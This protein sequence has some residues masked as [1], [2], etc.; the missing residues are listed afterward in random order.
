[1]LYKA[2]P[3]LDKKSL[4]ALYFSFINSYVNYANI[5]WGSTYRTSLKKINSLV[6]QA[7]RIL[8]NKDKYAHSRPLLRSINALDVYQLNVYQ[9]INLMYQVK[10]KNIPLTL[11]QKFKCISHN[12]PTNYSEN[13]YEIPKIKNNFAKFSISYRGP[14]PW[15]NFLSNASKEEESKT[16]FQKSLKIKLFDEENIIRFF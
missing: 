1:M 16:L 6:K 8:N 4:K 12:Y 3:I 7:S 15:N 10:R 14:Y 11:N 13:N 9:Y 5:V 2:K